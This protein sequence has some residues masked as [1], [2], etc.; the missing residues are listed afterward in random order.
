MKVFRDSKNESQ[1]EEALPISMERFSHLND[2]QKEDDLVVYMYDSNTAVDQEDDVHPTKLSSESSSDRAGGQK[3]KRRALCLGGL[4]LAL[5]LVVSLGTYGIVSNKL[6]ASSTTSSLVSSAF[7]QPPTIKD[8]KEPYLEL[9]LFAG[10]NRLV[11]D[12]EAKFLEDAVMQ[13]YNEA[14]GGCTDEYERW[15]YAKMVNQS[16]EPLY[17]VRE[18]MN[19]TMTTTF[20][21]KYSHVIRFQTIISCDGCPDDE[22]FASEYPESFDG[23]DAGD[24]RRALRFGGENFRP[25]SAGLVLSEIEAKI[26]TAIPDLGRIG[27]ATIMTESEETAKHMRSSYYASG[28]YGPDECVPAPVCCRE[29]CEGGIGDWD[30]SMCNNA[31]LSDDDYFYGD[32][33]GTGYGSPGYGSPGY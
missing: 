13:G 7:C 27:E 9:V 20:S 32:D 15:I 11:D 14:S 17:Y 22:A 3:K 5:I 16:T 23:I 26:T 6:G 18:D 19:G 8:T 21:E 31:P 28:G 1:A 12:M 29:V 2:D 10:S 4:A 30:C 24:E 33:D 25:L